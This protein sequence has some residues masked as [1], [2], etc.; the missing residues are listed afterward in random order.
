M[1]TIIRSAKGP[2]PVYIHHHPGGDLSQ[3]PVPLSPG[4]QSLCPSGRVAPRPMAAK[5]IE[6]II[7][8]I[9]Y[10]HHM[11]IAPEPSA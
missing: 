8:C 10:P 11:F 1:I 3:A 2:F 6:T 7:F 5:N 4:I 9:A